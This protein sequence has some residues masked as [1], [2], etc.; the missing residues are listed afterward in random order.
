MPNDRTNKTVGQRMTEAKQNRA[1]ISSVRLNKPAS[2]GAD[3]SRHYEI[4]RRKQRKSDVRARRTTYVVHRK[5]ERAEGEP[6]RRSLAAILIVT[7]LVLIGAA[8]VAFYF[9]ASVDTITVTG[10]SRFSEQEIV[11]LS[12]LYT[13]RNIL[14]YDLAGARDGIEKNPYI[15]CIGVRRV[16]PHTIAIEVREREEFAAITASSGLSC[17]IDR[18][19]YV[20]DVSRRGDTSDMLSIRGLASMGFTTGTSII[21]DRSKLRPYTVMELINCMGD[22]VDS[23]EYIDVS[24]A[25][26]VKIGMRSGVTVL[27]G[28]SKDVAEKTEYMFRAIT[29]ADPDKLSGTVIYINSNG[30]ADIAYPTPQP[31]AP[32]NTDEPAETTDPD[33]AETPADTPEASVETTDE[34]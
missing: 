11:N 8:F 6:R 5:P 33:A 15:D 24:N 7:A 27:F 3:H 22:R 28:D 25:A 34:P 17:I 4:K 9:V 18:Q 23:V 10:N 19:G 31:T 14:L 32:A 12:G 1:S 29:K 21:S 20:L 13:G 2:E 30:T 16:L 26:S